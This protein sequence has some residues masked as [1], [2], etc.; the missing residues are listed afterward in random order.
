MT[1]G[2]A[3]DVVERRVLF[4]VPPARFKDEELDVPR[5]LLERKKCKVHIA[6]PNKR[7][8]FGMGGMRAMPDV[9]M[10][11]IDLNQ[12]DAVIF[13]GG[14]GCRDFWDH[15]GA[16]NLARQVVESGKV[17]G[18]SGMAP[19]ILA[20]AGLL[21]DREA[22]VYFSET[23][24]ITEHGARYNGAS[25]AVDGNILTCKGAE[26]GEKFALALI[27]CLSEPVSRERPPA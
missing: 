11:T 24:Q 27:K 26:A 18:A 1:G 25:V 17:L 12:Y 23:R 2:G 9:S 16:Q 10:E 5:R 14:M 21:Q 15:G 4:V 20:R 13:V 7:P 3:S 19:V 6:T 8:S 22:T